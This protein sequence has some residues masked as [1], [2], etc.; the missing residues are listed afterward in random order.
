M[1]RRAAIA[2]GENWS[3]DTYRLAAVRCVLRSAEADLMALLPPALPAAR[4]A[5]LADG[6]GSHRE[7][8]A[9]RH[10]APLNLIARAGT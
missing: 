1:V 9:N 5:S 10:K 2:I 6:A 8:P 3:N 7:R 4:T